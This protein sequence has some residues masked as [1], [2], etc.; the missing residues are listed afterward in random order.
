MAR[1]V[2]LFGCASV[3][4]G[5][6]A[7]SAC[8]GANNSSTQASTY[9]EADLSD[10]DIN[11]DRMWQIILEFSDSELDLTKFR[12]SNL[13]TQ[14]QGVYRFELLLD[15]EAAKAE[16]SRLLE[17]AE[18]RLQATS[19]DLARDFEC[20]DQQRYERVDLQYFG[21]GES[22]GPDRWLKTLPLIPNL[23]WDPR[24]NYR[25]GS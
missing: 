1:R 14:G 12:S 8:E 4:L 21:A 5:A 11:H 2:N 25:H 22:E 7:V 15:C 19:L 9:V 3:V 18:T 6:L 23:I 24:R 13:T 17:I 10:L 20:I 16:T